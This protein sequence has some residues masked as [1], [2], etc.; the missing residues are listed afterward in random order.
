MEININQ[1]LTLNL[2]QNLINA[3]E[4]LRLNSLEIDELIQKESSENVFLE[5]EEKNNQI[6]KIIKKY[7]E[8]IEDYDDNYTIETKEE[9][10]YE[11][12]FEKKQ[13]FKEYLKEQALFLK[14]PTRQIKIINFLIDNL[15]SKGYLIAEIKNFSKKLN[16]EKKE[17]Y[18]CLKILWTFEPK[19]VGAR[20][21]K[22]ALLLQ[23]EKKD[24][25]YYIIANH[26]EDLAYN[27]LEKIAKEMGISLSEVQEAKEKIKKLNPIPSRGFEGENKNIRYIVPEIFIKII[28]DKLEVYVEN[29]FN[30][31]LNI[32]T[33][34][35]ELMNKTE[36]D[37]TK[38][39]LMEKYN[40][41]LFF[42][43][44]MESRRINIE[45]VTK[46]IV[47][48]Q[49]EFFLKN[50]PLKILRLEDIA[51]R[52]NLSKS[53][54]SRISQNKYLQSSKGTI[55]LKDLFAKKATKQDMYLSKDE[56]LKEILNIIEKED[57]TKPLSDKKILEI[58]KN[59]N[60][61]LSRRTI[62]KYREEL[63]IPSSTIRKYKI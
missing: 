40:K 3:I 11:N 28:N 34:Y 41:A 13:S 60:M 36:D 17:I 8:S 26:L 10:R 43:E 23:V 38:K 14:L 51:Q 49:K 19:G 12:F 59:K 42:L 6:E 1:K 31:K 21:L 4:M 33:Y 54:I 9:R 16:V 32:N 5:I 61:N 50:E 22:E 56:I 48:F 25:I 44:A 58:L 37:K 55:L 39:Y 24:N 18:K 30:Y 29:S 53:T 62:A 45:K 47:E 27:K 46:E 20:N 15:D 63:S 35:I 7:R 52:T 2:N 57:K